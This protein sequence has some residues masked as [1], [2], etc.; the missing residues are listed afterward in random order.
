MRTY[1]IKKTTIAENAVRLCKNNFKNWFFWGGLVYNYV[2]LHSIK[3][4]KITLDSMAESHFNKINI[5]QPYIIY[6]SDLNDRMWFFDDLFSHQ[7]FEN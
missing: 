4:T 7:T 3:P 6:C 2:H 1:I 5:L